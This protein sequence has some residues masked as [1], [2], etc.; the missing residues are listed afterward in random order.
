MRR[1]LLSAVL[2]LSVLLSPLVASQDASY[3]FTTIDVPFSDATGTAAIGINNNG[4]I[5]GDY[6]DSS[7]QHGFLAIPDRR[8]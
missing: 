5:V 1:Y 6:R 8:R 4:Q 3:I 7:G 2:S